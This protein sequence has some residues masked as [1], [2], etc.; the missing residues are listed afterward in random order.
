MTYNPYKLIKVGNTSYCR[1]HDTRVL[2]FDHDTLQLTLNTDGY[3]SATT[4]KRMN[5]ALRELGL[6]YN[7]SQR[8]Y[9][10]YIK[11]P[12]GET[13]WPPS[14]QQVGYSFTVNIDTTT[15]TIT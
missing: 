9:L 15:H 2:S 8:D 7:V 11:T 3:F 1:Y 12:L 14:T 5:L 13:P 10:W 4:K 6:P